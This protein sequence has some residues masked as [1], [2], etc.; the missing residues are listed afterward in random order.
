MHSCFLPHWAFTL[1]LFRS[2]VGSVCISDSRY[3]TVRSYTNSNVIANNLAPSSRRAV[4]MALL[5]SLGNLG[6]GLIGS[7]IFIS[8]MAPHYY[9]GY[10]MCCGIT[11]AAGAT[12]W[13]LR[14]RYQKINKKRDLMTAEEIRS[15]YTEGELLDLG[16]H[17]P[18]YRYTL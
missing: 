2:S 7:N 11:F 1:L 4:G 3:V 15:R 9:L 18:F 12:A 17:S 13:F 6:G 16:D 14:W 10:G 8:T 5:I